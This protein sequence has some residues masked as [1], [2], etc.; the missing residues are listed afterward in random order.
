MRL[1]V[2][3]HP[4]GVVAD[5]VHAQGQGLDALQNLEGVHRTERR[6]HVAQRHHARPAD[7][8]R[9]AQCLGI[10]D[11]VVTHVGLVEAPEAGLVLGPRELAGVDDR[12]ADRGAMAAQVLRQGMHDD[13]GAML[14]GA[15]Q[16]GAGYRVVDDQRH[17]MGMRHRC[18]RGDVRHVAQRVAHRFAEHRLGAV[19]DQPRK[20]GRVARVRKTRLDA[21]LREGVREQVVG[22]AIQGGGRH[23]VVARLGDGLDGIT[24]GRHAAGHGQGADAALQRCDAGLQHA[25]GRIH[26]PAVDVAGHLQ[27]EQVR[28]M[29]RVVERIGH[30]LVDRDCHRPGRGGGG[31]AAVNGNGFDAHGASPEKTAS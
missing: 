30:R 23:D 27:V 29:L 12:A 16:V 13:V 4:Q 9:S 21:H 11:P 26:D 17:P 15:A 18:Q 10:D 2:A 7:V 28:A 3:R 25:V 1:Q 19:I 14:E 22:A 20:R 8:G 31:V 6:A 24:D 5:A